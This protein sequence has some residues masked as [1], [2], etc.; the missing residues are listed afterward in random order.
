MVRQ[1]RSK[2]RIFRKAPPNWLNHWLQ[3]L[4]Q[5]LRADRSKEIVQ[6]C[7]RKQAQLIEWWNMIHDLQIMLKDTPRYQVVKHTLQYIQRLRWDLEDLDRFKDHL[8]FYA[9]FGHGLSMDYELLYLRV[10]HEIKL[11]KD[12]LRNLYMVHRSTQPLG[13]NPHYPFL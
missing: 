8:H 11:E 1:R 2:Y 9:G 4:E 13:R 5:K 12:A 3:N 6:R 7:E 10:K